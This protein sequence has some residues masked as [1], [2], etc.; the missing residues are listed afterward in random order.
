MDDTTALAAQDAAYTLMALGWPVRQD[1][2]AMERWRIGDF[3]LTH[4]ELLAFAI[5][6]GVPVMQG[7]LP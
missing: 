1:G 3:A 2:D 5:R 4:A 7:R 6:R